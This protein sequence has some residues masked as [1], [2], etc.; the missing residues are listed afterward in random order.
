MLGI[1]ALL[2][3]LL[4][5][6]G[7]CQT[8]VYEIGGNLLRKSL[9]TVRDIRLDVPRGP[10]RWGRCPRCRSLKCIFDTKG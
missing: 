4:F 6:T 10:A 5:H 1:S 2:R 8:G 3:M 7:S 9:A